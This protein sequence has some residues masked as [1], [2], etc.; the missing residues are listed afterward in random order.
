[1]Q[2]Y[3]KQ[4]EALVSL[5]QHTKS[6]PSADA[7]YTQLRKEFPK[8]SLATVYRNL[9][10]LL[11]QNEIIKIDIGNG[12][13]H[14]DACTEPHY[15]FVCEQCSAIIDLDVPVWRELQDEV[16]KKTDLMIR[17]HSV[18]FYGICKKCQEN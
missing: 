7:L 5:L 17:S 18:L 6:H 15:H 11:E 8:I 14:Y 16:S 1:M 9:N 4:R 13:E 3:S 2:K 10:S 12:T